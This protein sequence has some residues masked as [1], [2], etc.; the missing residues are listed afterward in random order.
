MILSCE[1]LT[2]K[3]PYICRVHVPVFTLYCTV[4]SIFV[5]FYCSAMK[6]GL[7]YPVERLMGVDMASI[8]RVV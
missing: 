3:L 2:S 4:L 1:C 7:G 8:L 6:C 5:C